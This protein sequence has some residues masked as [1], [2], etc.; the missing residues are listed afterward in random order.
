MIHEGKGARRC[1]VDDLAAIHNGGLNVA[2]V[3]GHVKWLQLSYVN[4]NKQALFYDVW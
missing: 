2:Y 3:D 4:A 1:C